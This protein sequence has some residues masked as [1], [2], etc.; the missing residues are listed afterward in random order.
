[1]VVGLGVASLKCPKQKPS[2]TGDGAVFAVFMG[3]SNVETH[4]AAT[5]MDEF[6]KASEHVLAKYAGVHLMHFVFR[7]WDLEELSNQM[8]PH[9]SWPS[10]TIRSQPTNYIPNPTQFRHLFLFSST[11]VVEQIVMNRFESCYVHS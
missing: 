10:S 2:P 3:W 1:M 6:K 9:E 7:G 8:S 11:H 4:Q 5:K